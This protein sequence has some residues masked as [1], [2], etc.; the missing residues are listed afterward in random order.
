MKRLKNFYVICLTIFV[1]LLITSCGGSGGE[2][3][4]SESDEAEQIKEI[5]IGYLPWDEAVAV[6]FLWKALLE[7]K[8][9]K[10]KVVQSDVA[11]LFSGVAQGNIDLFLDVWMPV[12]HKS[13]M[14][15]FGED[16]EVIG[17]WYDQADSGLAVPDYI[18]IQSI[19]DLKNHKEKFGG[20]IISIEPGSGINELTKKG[21]MPTYGL[22]DWTLVDSSTPAMLSELK[23]AVSNKEPIVVTLW[24]PHWAFE[25]YNLRYL[26]DPENTLNPS[27]PEEI[28]AIANKNFKKDFPE[29]A[30][31][32]GEFKINLEQ[33]GTLESEINNGNDEQASVDKW[34]SENRSVAEEW[35]K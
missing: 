24:R 30:Q 9:Y 4:S 8:G 31:W 18:D 12:T 20:E 17:T 22:T 34:I 1:L 15:R 7:E 2:K 23:K 6:T 33:L 21:T 29:V 14:D 5:T 25:E 3:A 35:V 16:V 19:E 10:V 11:P 26:E 13:Y 32:L 28:Q 27:G